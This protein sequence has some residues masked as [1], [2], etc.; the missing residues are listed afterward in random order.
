MSKTTISQTEA[1]RL[2]KRVDYLEDILRRQARRHGSDW[3]GGQV[4]CT[5]ESGNTS[6]LAIAIRTARILGHGVVVVEQNGSITY[7]ALPHPEVK[8]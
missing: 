1:R 7:R 4:I 6:V 5:Q 2:R 3:P 8:P